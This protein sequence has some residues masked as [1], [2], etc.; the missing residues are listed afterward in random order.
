MKCFLVTH[1][2]KQ[3]HRQR[4]EGQITEEVDQGIARN[5][6]DKIRKARMKKEVQLA[7]HIKRQ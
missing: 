3:K 5:F 4:K 6:R 7:R 1:T 2:S